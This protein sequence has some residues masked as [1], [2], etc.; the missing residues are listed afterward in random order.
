[1]LNT[2]LTAVLNTQLTAELTGAPSVSAISLEVRRLRPNRELIFHSN[3]REKGCR[4]SSRPIS[5][6]IAWN[7]RRSISH[8]V[9]HLGN[10][11]P[12]QYV[13]PPPPPPIK[14]L[15]YKTEVFLVAVIHHV[16]CVPHHHNQLEISSRQ[17]E[18]ARMKPPGYRV[19]ISV[20]DAT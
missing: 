12:T 10:I 2:P 17:D 4:L 1:M 14:W 6:A 7:K 15:C 13:I 3:Y 18:A 11:F 20:P 16:V 5:W 19:R 8:N 9:C